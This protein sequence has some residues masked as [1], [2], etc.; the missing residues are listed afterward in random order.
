MVEYNVAGAFRGT[1]SSTCRSAE[2]RKGRESE[3]RVARCQPAFVFRL[4]WLHAR[5][6]KLNKFSAERFDAYQEPAI[7]WGRKGE[8]AVDFSLLL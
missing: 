2:N 4:R 3:E 7:S 8:D 5:D 1:G 6:E